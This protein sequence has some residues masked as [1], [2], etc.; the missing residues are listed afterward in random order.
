MRELHGKSSNN[1]HDAPKH[2]TNKIF[3]NH[4]N[5][6]IKLKFEIAIIEF[7]E[8]KTLNFLFRNNSFSC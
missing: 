5:L 3:R 4:I 8:V 7:F 2:A 6:G 1:K